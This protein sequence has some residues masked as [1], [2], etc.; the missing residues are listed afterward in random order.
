MS[1]EAIEQI[2]QNMIGSKE[3]RHKL[4]D[5]LEQ[6]EVVEARI[7]IEGYTDNNLVDATLDACEEEIKRKLHN[8]E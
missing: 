8:V 2:M 7:G 4:R 3:E 5:G 1:A 6:K